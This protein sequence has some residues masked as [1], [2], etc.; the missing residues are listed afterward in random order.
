MLQQKALKL[1]RAS[2]GSGKTFAL[3]AHY[4]ILLLSGKGKYREILA[5]T[6]TNKATAEMKERILGA[7]EELSHSGFE[8]S[9]FSSVLKESYPGLTDQAVRS[10]A[11]EIYTAILH[12]YSRFSVSTI[13]GFVQQLIRSFAF[14][15]NLDSGYKLEMNQEKVKEELV[16]ALNLQMEKEPELLEWVS[17]LAI[18]QIDDGKDW[19]YRRALKALADEIFKERYSR[20]EA[21]MK[22]MGDD[23]PKEFDILRNQINIG[24]RTFKKDIKAKTIK[25]KELFDASGVELVDLNGK[26]RNPLTKL[27]KIIDEDFDQLP[28]LDKLL[29]DFEQWPQKS[30]K[31]TSVIMQL[32]LTINPLLAE[33]LSYYHEGIKIYQTYQ[34]IN[35]NGS[36]LRLMQ[37]MADLLSDYRSENR[38]LLISD[39]QQLLR[40]ITG[41]DVDNPSFIWEKTGNK[42]KH[43]LFDEFQDTSSFQWM[44][45]LPL[46]RNA[47]AEGSQG[48][49]SAHLVVGDVKQSIYRWRNGDWRILHS[50][51]KRDLAAVNV[52]EESLSFNRRSSENIIRFNNF[53]YSKLP[54]ILQQN[55]NDVFYELAP[56][57]LHKDW[58]K[59]NSSLIEKAYEGSSQEMTE[60]TP[61]GGKIELRFFT[62]EPKVYSPED[63][64]EEEENPEAAVYTIEKLSE[65]LKQGI[66]MRDIGIL[67]RSNREAVMILECIYQKNN[68]KILS[69]A[70]GKPFQ[71]FSGEALKIVNNPAVALLLCT[72]KLLTTHESESGIYKAECA[73]LYKQIQNPDQEYI[74]IENQHW[75]NM[76]LGSVSTM[77]DI[78]PPELCSNLDSF[79]HLPVA[80]LTEKLMR[81]YGL[82]TSATEKLIP[83]LLAFRDQVAVFTEAGDQGIAAFL[84]W[85][86]NE[87]SSKALPSSESQDA[88]QVMTIHKSK[89]LEFTAVIVPFL[90]WK[91]VEYSNG[92]KKKYLWVDAAAAGFDKF[93]SFPVD[94]NK[95]LATTVFAGDFFEEIMLS[96]M[97]LINTLYVATTRAKDYLCLICPN[98]VIKKSGAKESSAKNLQTILSELFLSGDTGNLDWVSD[99]MQYILGEIPI[100]DAP[101]ITLSETK[102]LRIKT[103]RVNEQLTERFKRN[104]RHE[105]SWF[106]AR[107]RKGIVLHQLLERLDSLDNLDQLI[108]IQVQE[109]LIREAERDE[110]RQAVTDV[111]MQDEIKHW[112]DTAKSVI[113]EKDMIIDS[114]TVKRPDK[115]FILDDRAVLLD[116]KFGAQNNKYM[117]DIGLYR[118]SLM[119]MGEFKQV[120][121]YLWY[122]Q[123]CKLQ[124]V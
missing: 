22:A 14:E 84:E 9:K 86:D 63:Q 77:S 16:T 23:K 68:Q 1:V 94:I 118:D 78:L 117:A 80:E 55:L 93:K 50:Y 26:S 104:S 96:Y 52:S 60:H 83:F 61:P 105:D 41:S 27:Q 44:N 113:S 124:K 116:F 67:V 89:G 95:S 90:S 99:E 8:N 69:E 72:F 19:D 31:D 28:T 108:S 98:L 18:E 81:M 111:L 59:E 122:A 7:L 64:E 53:L 110:I 115:L 85:W 114:G 12:D 35:K 74:E 25:I 11:S 34:A 4:L 71:I 112:F 17:N 3:T 75:M 109:G 103:Y 2:A 91:L 92:S 30:L 101:A 6:F 47:I 24:I 15:L 62:K 97:D 79:K 45:F 33:L 40:G 76:A 42:Y 119:R 82:G 29:N 58:E 54:A 106:N 100:S 102:P 73:R 43:F 107:Q 38:V 13:D 21:A 10:R 65:I 57:F 70:A 49:H 87:G 5:V 120:D 121:A 36:Y 37:G 66:S 56:E 39:A 48:G 88:V 46:L 20:F 32:Y 51:L 123:D